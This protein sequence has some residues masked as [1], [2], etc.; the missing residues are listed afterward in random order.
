MVKCKIVIMARSITGVAG[1]KHKESESIQ[2]NKFNICS[3]TFTFSLSGL[4]PEGS[5]FQHSFGRALSEHQETI[6]S[7][8]FMYDFRY[9]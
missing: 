9:G 4:D 7:Y 2:Q 3:M 6:L 5:K 8:H 1:D